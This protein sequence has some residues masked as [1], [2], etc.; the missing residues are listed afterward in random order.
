M[1]INYRKQVDIMLFAM[2]I[3]DKA[4]TAAYSAVK[5]AWTLPQALNLEGV[6]NHITA[7]AI[8]LLTLPAVAAFSKLPAIRAGAVLA[9]IAALI[10]TTYFMTYK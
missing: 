2:H 5:S 4:K 7:I 8:A 3:L 1:I 9:P 10:G 6:E